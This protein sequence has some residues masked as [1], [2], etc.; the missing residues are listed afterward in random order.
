M[1]LVT[2]V[3]VLLVIFLVITMF[4][5]KAVKFI[6][7]TP[8]EDILKGAM[9]KAVEYQQEVVSY[10]R[11]QIDEFYKYYNDSDYE[12]ICAEIFHFDGNYKET[13]K[14]SMVYLKENY[15]NAE[16]YNVERASIHKQINIVN[17]EYTVKVPTKFAKK[18]NM[19]V[20]FLL[21]ENKQKNLTM[22]S[23]NIDYN[24]KK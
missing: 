18:E 20:S 13:C 21:I 17:S 19:T 11:P 16:S 5:V 24:Y 2:L 3:S 9:N 15:G 12:Y 4:I 10:T 22:K 1:V 8:P 23:V 7:S 6:S 14:N